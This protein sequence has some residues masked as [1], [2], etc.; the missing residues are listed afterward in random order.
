MIDIDIEH[1]VFGISEMF[2]EYMLH[3]AGAGR[4][5]MEKQ[6]KTTNIRV[7]STVLR[8]TDVNSDIPDAVYVNP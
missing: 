8:I 4:S 3:R 2:S 7:Q 1:I 6:Y 5:Y